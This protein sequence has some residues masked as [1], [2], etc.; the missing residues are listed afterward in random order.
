MQRT[1]IITV[2]II[3]I[4]IIIIKYN[5]FKSTLQ[6]LQASLTLFCVVSA[7]RNT[8]SLPLQMILRNSSVAAALHMKQQTATHN[9]TYESMWSEFIHD[10]L[11]PLVNHTY[12]CHPFNKS[13]R[14][15]ITK[16]TTPSINLVIHQR[17]CSPVQISIQNKISSSYRNTRQQISIAN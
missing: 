1:P 9:W 8:P 13:P 3:I 11:L 15:A 5:G 12:K 16:E 14:Q 17:T 6:W 7:G 4:I 2:V 10:K